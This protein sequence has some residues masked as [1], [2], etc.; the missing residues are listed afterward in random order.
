MTKN[1]YGS[2][3]AVPSILVAFMLI[4]GF[5]TVTNA[6]GPLSTT[7]VAPINI[8]SANPSVA[9]VTEYP[10]VICKIKAID[11]DTGAVSYISIPDGESTED[12][13]EDLGTQHFY[14]LILETKECDCIILWAS[15]PDLSMG[16]KINLTELDSNRCVVKSPFAV[17]SA[18][19]ACTTSEIVVKS[20]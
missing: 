11:L 5:T 12:Q 9:T 15:T 13:Y 1:N 7:K 20:S 6:A 19:I 17:Q 16:G 14:K 4:A 2:S 10:T 3:S 18:S 8:R